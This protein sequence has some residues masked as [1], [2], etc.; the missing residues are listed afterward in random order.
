M[1]LNNNYVSCMTLEGR[2]KFM[3]L[4]RKGRLRTAVNFITAI[5]ARCFFIL[6]ML[7]AIW[8]ASCVTETNAVWVLMTVFGLFVIECIFCIVK[9][10][11]QE[12]KWLL[13]YYYYAE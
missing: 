8:A 2:K 9:R 11:G 12:P 7:F 13:E 4:N 10:K 1:R 3:A 5:L 6:H